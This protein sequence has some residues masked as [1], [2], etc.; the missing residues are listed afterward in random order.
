[1]FIQEVHVSS[2]LLKEN[3]LEGLKHV[4]ISSTVHTCA[5]TRLLLTALTRMDPCTKLR[6][7]CLITI[8][9]ALLS[10]LSLK[11]YKKINKKRKNNSVP[12]SQET[13]TRIL[14]N[15]DKDSKLPVE[16]DAGIH[17]NQR[18]TMEV[19]HHVSSALKGSWFS[20]HA[21]PWLR[22]RENTACSTSQSL[23]HVRGGVRSPR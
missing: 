10:L 19:L 1:M 9:I 13:I 4:C 17:S 6:E 12:P 22:S 2:L 15:R 16:E 8:F 5:Q 14:E 23:S 20:S 3:E 21:K 7:V 18:H 11:H